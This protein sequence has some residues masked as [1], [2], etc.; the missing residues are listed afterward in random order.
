MTAD[1]AADIRDALGWISPDCERG[2]WVRILM[3]VKAALGDAGRDIAEAWSAQADRYNA[4]DFRDT[5]RSINEGGG[6]GPGTLFFLARES[7]MRRDAAPPV[8]INLK[9]VI[10]RQKPEPQSSTLDYA[11]AIWST[12]GKPA[13]R[14]DA[15]VAAHPYCIR[16]GIRHAAGAGRMAVSGRL[17]GRNADCINAEGVKQTFGRKG[18]LVLGNDLDPSLPVL[19]VEGWASAVHALNAYQWNACAVVAGGKHRLQQVAH[20]IDARDPRRKKTVCTEVDA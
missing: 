2:E 11:R 14:D 1:T 7:G 15:Y 10:S 19:V 16:K 20:E 4:R 17:V 9:A 6:I 13:R 18:I 5:W 3:A 12:A 8:R